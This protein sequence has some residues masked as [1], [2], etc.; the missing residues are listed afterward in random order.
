MQSRL[1]LLLQ[2]RDVKLLTPLKGEPLLFL[3]DI[4]ESLVMFAVRSLTVIRQR[5]QIRLQITAFI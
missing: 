2:D 3:S 5:H 1:T 4:V